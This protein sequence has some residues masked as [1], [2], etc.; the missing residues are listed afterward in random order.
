MR[1]YLRARRAYFIG[2]FVVFLVFFAVFRLYGLPLAAVA[3]PSLI[4]AAAG[5]VAL[6]A[7]ALRFR[8]RRRALTA[9][10]DAVPQSETELPPEDAFPGA[11]WRKIARALIAENARRANNAR[12]QL[13]DCAEYYT[14][15]AHQI[16]TPISAMR[17]TL[18]NEDT[19]LS[20]GLSQEL[21]RVERY[22]EMALTFARLDSESTD[23]VFRSCSLD[24]VARGAIRRFSGEFIARRLKL[25]YSAANVAVVTDE[26]W[27]RFAVE[28]VLS[29][30]L[31]YTRVGEIKVSVTE[32]AKIIVD[33]TGIGIA[34]ED[35]PR[36]FE[37]GY[38][39]FNG[40]VDLRA[41]G[42]GLYLCRR[43]LARLGAE[44]SVRSK[45][46]VG[47]TVVISLNPRE[48]SGD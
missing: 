45:V 15:W 48:V 8:A 9:L 34:P 2:F 30:A 10:A 28:Q 39:G 37:K 13:N 1:R 35:L 20:R 38:T 26:K 21:G 25:S 23:F 27:L 3:Y 43:V 14:A 18:Q 7:D 46:D 44:I 12:D 33:D 41:S 19:A 22:V 5:L 17:L 42:V 24:E 47:T 29:N 36:V 16:K 40:R 31:K 6:V 4:C 11:E 32:D